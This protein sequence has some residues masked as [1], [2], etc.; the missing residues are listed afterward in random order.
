MSS[1]QARILISSLWGGGKKSSSENG[2]EA[3]QVFLGEFLRVLI[4]D[5]T[6]QFG[7]KN[8]D[9]MQLNQSGIKQF[10]EKMRGWCSEGENMAFGNLEDGFS[11]ATFWMIGMETSFGLRH[12]GRAVFVQVLEA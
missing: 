7:T 8:I 2:P 3:I 6:I 11:G 5:T 4:F 1:P 10:L 12:F 9:N